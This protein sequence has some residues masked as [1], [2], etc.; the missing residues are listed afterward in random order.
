[1]LFGSLINFC[2]ISPR[3]YPLYPPQPDKCFLTDFCRGQKKNTRCKSK[4]LHLITIVILS[5]GSAFQDPSEILYEKFKGTL[6]VIWLHWD[7]N[8]FYKVIDK[9]IIYLF[10]TWPDSL[11]VLLHISKL[12]GWCHLEIMDIALKDKTG[13]VYWHLKLLSEGL[14]ACRG[15]K[16]WLQPHLGKQERHPISQSK[17]CYWQ[18]CSFSCLLPCWDCNHSQY[19]TATAMCYCI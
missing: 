6:H 5:S 10:K 14:W 18:L 15:R 9:K 1:M 2:T 3:K 19:H 8:L 7:F 4:E 12:Y 17:R 13:Q 11:T 16:S